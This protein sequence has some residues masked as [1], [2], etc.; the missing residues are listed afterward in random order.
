M[1]DVSIG[2]AR[3]HSPQALGVGALILLAWD[4]QKRA[5]R[6]AWARGEKYGL[7]FNVPLEP[8]ELAT[9]GVAA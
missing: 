9:L 4:N 6:V 3:I 5:A 2:G 1:L 7:R 8:T